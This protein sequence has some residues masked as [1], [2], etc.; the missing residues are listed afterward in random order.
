MDVQLE[1]LQPLQPTATQSMVEQCIDDAS[2]Q[3]QQN[4]LSQQTQQFT[5]D[6][7]VGQKIALS[8][9]QNA[10]A[11]NRIAPAYLFAGPDGVGKTLAAIAFINQ[12]LGIAN[13]QNHP[14][15]LWI[16]PTYVHQGE[17]IPATRA[18]E[19]E[20]LCKTPLAIRIDQIRKVSEFLSTSALDV[21]FKVAVIQHADAIYPAAANALLKTLEQPISGILIL[22]S[23]NPAQL[24]PTVTS[25][26]QKIP[27]FSLLSTEILQV[28]SQGGYTEIIAR[29]EIIAL[30]NGSPGRAIYHY[31]KLRSLPP[32]LL[33]HLQLPPTD[34]ITALSL[35]KEAE[36]LNFQ[37]QLWLLEYLE[38]CW[39]HQLKDP[40]WLA[41][42]DNAKNQLKQLAQPRLVW[43]VL[44]IP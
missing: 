38:Y 16:E 22:I 24:L 25:R 5:F 34:L 32:E 13:L 7:I 4:R 10:I 3:A 14:D 27:F 18:T 26:C 33:S 35:G 31:Q 29:P 2:S 44:L 8:A 17:L 9:L 30:A 28:L 20:L 21:S 42:L 23:S 19:D 6:Q 11:S 37:Q 36:L 12:W 40:T 41:K 1:L 39:W 43:D 15:L